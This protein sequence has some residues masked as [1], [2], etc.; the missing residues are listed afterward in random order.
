MS[1]KIH[2]PYY[3]ISNT[4]YVVVRDSAGK[5]W[6]TVGKS[7]VSWIDGNIAKYVINSTYGE[8]SLYVASFPTDIS[9]GYYTIMIFIRSG[10]SPDVDNDIW[11]GSMSAYWDKVNSN[12]LGVRVD[13]LVEYSSGQR[14][15][16]KALEMVASAAGGGNVKKTYTVTDD[17]DN[18]IDGVDVWVTTDVAGS[19]TIAS[20]VTNIQGQVD[21]YL[22]AGTYYMWSQKA[23]YDFTNPDTEVVA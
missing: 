16:E 10:V 22:N 2:I 20:G 6:D 4:I 1:N 12:L 9:N 17:E 15:S 18:P 7:F 19:N 14:F 5:V 3:K 21:F 8:G 11:I 13:A 23:G